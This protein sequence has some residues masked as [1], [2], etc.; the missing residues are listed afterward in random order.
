MIDLL[1][2]MADLTQC[3][4]HCG[5]RLFFAYTRFKFSMDLQLS[6]FLMKTANVNFVFIF[7]PC[8][9]MRVIN[10]LLLQREMKN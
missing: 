4:T 8:F 9:K 3:D 2:K 6:L 1:V 5:V 7:S 10:K